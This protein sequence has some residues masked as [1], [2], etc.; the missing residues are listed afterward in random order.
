MFVKHIGLLL[1]LCSGITQACLMKKRHVSQSLRVATILS[2]KTQ[3][4]LFCKFP[5]KF[6]ALEQLGLDTFAHQNNYYV[7]ACNFGEG[8]VALHV[9]E[10]KPQKN[11]YMSGVQKDDICKHDLAQRLLR[12]GVEV[13]D[14]AELFGQKE[15]HT[16]VDVSIKPACLRLAVRTACLE[17]PSD[18]E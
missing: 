3:G 1:L 5:Q 7:S 9:T 18:I 4:Y 6:N 12:V 8:L 2:R 10:K 13:V 11:V 14:P 16:I 17:K 15:D